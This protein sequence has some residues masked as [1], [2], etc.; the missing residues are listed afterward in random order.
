MSSQGKSEVM[1]PLEWRPELQLHVREIDQ[2]HEELLHRA[3]VLEESIDAGRP[4]QEL[5]VMLSALIDFTEI[6]L[7]TEEELML[8]R[9]YKGY[10][11]HKAEHAVLLN[12]AYLVRH[13]LSNGAIHPCHVLSL[14]IQAWI[15]QHIVGPDR[16]FFAF[17]ASA[18]PSVGS[19]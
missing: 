2:Q 13:E 4:L 10:S 16:Q 8:A 18:H 5:Q 1:S 17:L 3:R 12:Q 15:N 19:Y 7:H 9:S 11:A 14:F 6:H